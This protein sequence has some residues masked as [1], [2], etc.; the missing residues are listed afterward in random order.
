MIQEKRF[1][2]VPENRRDGFFM[3]VLAPAS[4]GQASSFALTSSFELTVFE[5][6]RQIGKN[7]RGG[8]WEYYFEGDDVSTGFM[9]PGSGTFDLV[10]LGGWGDVGEVNAIE[11]GLACCL[12][13]ASHLSFGYDFDAQVFG[14]YHARLFDVIYSDGQP[15]DEGPS[16]ALVSVLD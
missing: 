16:S 1:R 5:I 6:A 3:K 4:V 2:K 10:S 12:M 7:Y 8:W 13:A 15:E 14:A 9:A 11:F